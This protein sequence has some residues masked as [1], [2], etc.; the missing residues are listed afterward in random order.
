MSKSKSMSMSKSKSK[1]AV[2]AYPLSPGAFCAVASSIP[3][4][5]TAACADFEPLLPS[6][7]PTQ[8]AVCEP[9]FD[10]TTSCAT[11]LCPQ[12]CSDALVTC[13][14]LQCCGGTVLDGDAV[15]A[16]LGV[17][18]MWNATNNATNTTACAEFDLDFELCPCS[19]DTRTT[20]EFCGDIVYPVDCLE[21]C[22]DYVDNCCNGELVP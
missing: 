22:V 3:L 17:S 14:E 15:C 7:C 8:D 4:N 5:D 16:L 19:S 2:P 9:T 10:L 20:A 11:S 6:L 12:E 1:S 21:G 18:D 13:C